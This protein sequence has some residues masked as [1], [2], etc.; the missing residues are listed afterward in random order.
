MASFEIEPAQ[1]SLAVDLSEQNVYFTA[2]VD[3]IYVFQLS[4]ADGSY[5][6]AM[7]LYYLLSACFIYVYSITFI[8]YVWGF[9]FLIEGFFLNI[10]TES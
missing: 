10:E 9:T 4:S 3:P 2:F 8:Y 7:Q 1:K 6:S 5:I